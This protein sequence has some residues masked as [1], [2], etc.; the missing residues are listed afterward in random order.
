M[1]ISESLSGP[2][3]CEVCGQSKEM[4]ISVFG[5]TAI[6]R[7]MCKCEQEAY[8]KREEEQVAKEKMIRLERL[9]KYSLMDEQFKRCRFENF[10]VDE[11]NEQ[12]YN[13]GRNYCENWAEMKANNVGLLLY[14]P[15]GTGKTFLV[16]CIAN[17]LLEQLVPVIIISSIGLL[18]RIK[19][20][21]NRGG[22]EAEVEI[23]N[24]LKNADL[25]IIDDLGTESAT[26]W[27]ME[28]IYEI[29]D[30]RYRDMKPLIITTNLTREALKDKLASEDGVSRTYD[31]II[32]M[33]YPLEVIG[34][35]RR[36]DIARNKEEA[37]KK[38][39]ERG[40]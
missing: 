2:K 14:G 25:L 34:P 15:P 4:E 23:I 9:R 21:Y 29:V 12:M 26:P 30:S 3:I 11:Y 24:N 38:L 27:A 20:T 10:I 32:E 35:S 31:R 8:R 40:D 18:N 33:S 6:V 16:S 28:K 37:I 5:R 39:S 17:E 22:A 13:L 1:Q 7:V 36:R 19:E